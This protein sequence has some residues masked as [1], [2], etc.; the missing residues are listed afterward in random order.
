MCL[1]IFIVLL[2]NLT[3][4]ITYL[5][6]LAVAYT[7]LVRRSHMAKAPPQRA[8]TK[9][10][11]QLYYS[12]ILNIM[13]GLSNY[14]FGKVMKAAIMYEIFGIDQTTEF[15]ANVNKGPLLA[16]RTLMNELDRNLESWESTRQQK[17]KAANQRWHAY[18]APASTSMH[19]DALDAVE[20]ESSSVNS[21]V[22]NSEAS[23]QS[24]ID[25][26]PASIVSFLETWYRSLDEHGKPLTSTAK[27]LIELDIKKYLNSYSA[28]AISE[29]IKYSIINNYTTIFYDRLPKQA[30]TKY[31]MYTPEDESHKKYISSDE[32]HKLAD[33]AKDIVI[34]RDLT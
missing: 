4:A 9:K 1:T 14:N 16:L 33:I 7:L 6:C 5:Y 11:F 12:T 27:S 19:E 30:P 28:E 31:K 21:S 18:D 29:L 22:E 32:I 17:I 23:C 25:T 13:D 26:L 3:K 15:E 34:K 24:A 2:Y 8:P 20:G 10:S